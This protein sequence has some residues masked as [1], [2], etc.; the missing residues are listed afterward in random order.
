MFE[1]L[2]FIDPGTAMLIAGGASAGGSIL[3]GLFGKK[4]AED[5]AKEQ[6]AA[7]RYQ[8]KLQAQTSKEAMF[9]SA[10][11]SAKQTLIDVLASRNKP[12]YVIGPTPAPMS[13]LDQIN[14]K[15][16]ALLKGAA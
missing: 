15:I 9:Y 12:V 6:A 11:E 5:A 10:A 14:W 2:A 8:A 13:W 1:I 16:H 4:G 3:G 7:I